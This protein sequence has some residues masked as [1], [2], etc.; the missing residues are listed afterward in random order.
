MDTTAAPRRSWIGDVGPFLLAS[1]GFSWGLWAVALL[2]GGD[3]A[4]PVVFALYAV[5]ACGPSLAGLTI[6]LTSTGPRP[7][8]P[9]GATR[10]L[11]AALLVGAGPGVA[12]AFATPLF[13]GPAVDPSTASGIVAGA[14]GLLPFLAFALVAGPLAEE[15]GWRG[16]AQPVLRRSLSPAATSA[17]LGTI[18]ALWHLPLFLLAG[19]YQAGM[20]LFTVQALGFFV[21]MLPLSVCYWWVTERL[22]GG[23]PA[24]VLLHLAGNLTLVLLAVQSVVGGSIFLAVLILLAALLLWTQPA[25]QPEPAVS[26]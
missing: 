8:R 18:W 9:A 23:V 22:R 6:R 5:G 21:S 7:P 10:W 25:R 3:I 20:G 19:T 17:V 11:P 13:G 1:F 16:H 14:G 24:A 26:A 2:L 4:D 15:F 12:A